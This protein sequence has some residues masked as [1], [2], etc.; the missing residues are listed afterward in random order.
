MKKKRVFQIYFLYMLMRCQG[1]WSRYKCLK[2][3]QYY[4][5]QRELRVQLHVKKI[6]TGIG[7]L[8]IM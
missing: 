7:I 3:E 1:A 4:I 8:S 6:C 2:K 5:I